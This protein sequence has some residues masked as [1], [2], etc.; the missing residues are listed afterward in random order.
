MLHYT[1][2]PKEVLRIQNEQ[3]KRGINLC[4]WMLGAWVSKKYSFL[5]SYL[6][7]F[8]RAAH[9]TKTFPNV[10]PRLYVFKN[11]VCS[12]SKMSILHYPNIHKH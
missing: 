1:P 8:L 6:T 12:I 5:K 4:L 2:L 9:T 3:A 10:L 7:V 11:A